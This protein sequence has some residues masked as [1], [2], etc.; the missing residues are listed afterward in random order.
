MVSQS[1][2]ATPA[3]DRHW[4]TP[5]LTPYWEIRP[6][7]TGDRHYLCAKL[8]DRRI[9]IDPDRAFIL[10][11]FSGKFT[12]AQIQRQYERKRNGQDPQLVATVIQE[13]IELGVFAHDPDDTIADRPI[14]SLRSC[15][16][17]DHQPEG[18]W[19][20]NN[21]IA[22][23]AI[24]VANEDKPAIEAIGWLRDAEL[25]Q[26]YKLSPQALAGFQKLL[27]ANA[28]LEGIEP[29]AKPRGKFNPMQLLFFKKKLCDPDPW[30]SRHV[31]KLRWIWT[32]TFWYS[33]L[34]SLALMGV[35]GFAQAAD[36]VAYGL[37]LWEKQGAGLL[38]KYLIAS[39]VVLSIHELGH[40]FTLK[41]FGK[42]VKSMGLMF[43]CLIPAAYTNSTNSYGLPRYQRLLVV[44]AGVLTQ[45]AIA[46][47]ALLAWNLATVGQWIYETSYLLFSASLFTVLLNLNPLAKFDGYHLIVA[48]TRI[49]DLR[50]RAF[51]YYQRKFKG[52]SEIEFPYARTILAIYAPLSLLYLVGIFGFLFSKIL[53]FALIT[54][55]APIALVFALWL[56]YYTLW[57][58]EPS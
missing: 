56:A 44:G 51:A 50:R 21:P 27:S 43:M 57:D 15:L 32:R 16:E 18:Y 13:L 54:L 35:V 46:A 58:A 20:L 9:E 55:P 29:P 24:T 5:N 36:L 39:L 12:I 11:H 14:G 42:P 7:K 23:T 19:I 22:E 30:L 38:V 3:F 49:N 28:M 41:H 34:A 17:W 52:E 40:A 26:Q 31:S 2:Q 37:E 48:A 25:C 33:F 8:D 47:I 10:S 4:H 1:N 6:S 53:H 45:L